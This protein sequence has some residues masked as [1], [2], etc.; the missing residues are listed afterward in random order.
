[1]PIS[2]PPPDPEPAAP[3]TQP[4]LPTEAEVWA[5]DLEQD[6][7]QSSE[8]AGRPGTDENAPGFIKPKRP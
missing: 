7:K 8:Q 1:M 3:P 4:V 6:A 5:N 2:K